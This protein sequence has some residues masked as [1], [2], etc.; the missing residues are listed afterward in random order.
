MFDELVSVFQKLVSAMS[1][2]QRRAPHG[3]LTPFCLNKASE[4]LFRHSRLGEVPRATHMS[5]QQWLSF[6]LSGSASRL[7]SRSRRRR[8]PP[9][10][11]RP[12]LGQRQTLHVLVPEV[13]SH[14][15]PVEDFLPNARVVELVT[16]HSCVHDFPKGVCL[17]CSH[18]VLD[19]D[20]FVFVNNLPML[21]TS[22]TP[23]FLKQFF[24]VE[25]FKKKTPKCCNI[26]IPLKMG[27][28][29]NKSWKFNAHQK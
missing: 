16:I 14:G 15:P 2:I 13:L 23:G 6:T 11:A 10:F 26:T 1:K 7:L 29:T 3:L 28:V 12:P 22:C 20:C 8:K 18:Q 17:C 27:L 25:S 21:G 19:T 5:A 4:V 24:C 9:L